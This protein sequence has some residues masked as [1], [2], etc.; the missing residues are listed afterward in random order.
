MVILYL[1][2]SPQTF[3]WIICLTLANVL[4][5]DLTHEFD[6]LTIFK[7]LNHDKVHFWHLI[8][9]L[10]TL[11]SN[12][13]V[14]Q[15]FPWNIKIINYAGDGK[16]FVLDKLS[17]FYLHFYRSWLP[18]WPGNL[19]WS[20]VSESHSCQGQT[21]TLFWDLAFG[22]NFIGGLRNLKQARK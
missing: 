9:K 12:L 15:N 13:P 1:K 19:I 6:N 21:E 2:I 14:N 3:L 20:T 18:I 17:K 7:I 4:Q 16:N 10:Q 11:K 8:R 22:G 5:I